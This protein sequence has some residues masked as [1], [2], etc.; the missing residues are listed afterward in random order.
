MVGTPLYAAPEIIIWAD[1]KYN[2]K[3]DVYSA[4]SILYEML[5][6]ERLLSWESSK[7]ENMDIRNLLMLK[8][9]EGGWKIDHPAIRDK[10]KWMQLL[11]GMLHFDPQKRMSFQEVKAFLQGDMH[12]SAIRPV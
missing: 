12:S 7:I 10:P 6:S 9:N 4:G 1:G 2:E 8:K 5:T 3:C 11:A